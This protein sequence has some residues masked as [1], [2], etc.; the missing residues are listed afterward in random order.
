M[1]GVSQQLY[2]NGTNAEATTTNNLLSVDSDGFTV[3]LD[4]AVNGS[5]YTYVA[6]NWLLAALRLATLMAALRQ[7]CLRMLTQGFQ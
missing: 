6:W 7:A 1:R 4:S 2:S 3:G 5:G